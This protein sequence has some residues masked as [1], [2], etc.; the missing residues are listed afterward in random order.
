MMVLSS[1]IYWQ[2]GL[3]GDKGRYIDSWIHERCGPMKKA[4]IYTES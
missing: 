3:F 2:T 1:N 4:V